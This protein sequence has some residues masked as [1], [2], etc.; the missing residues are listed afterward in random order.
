MTVSAQHELPFANYKRDPVRSVQQPVKEKVS[1]AKFPAAFAA[2]KFSNARGWMALRA[3][4]LRR[5]VSYWARPELRRCSSSCSVGRVA[6]HEPCAQFL[7]SLIDTSKKTQPQNAN[8]ALR[9]SSNRSVQTQV[10]CG[11]TIRSTG[12]L[13]AGGKRPVISFWAFCHLPQVPGYLKR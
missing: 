8:A 9:H 1:A 13:A 7:P 10:Q 6:L 5:A 3:G 2:P 4:V 11:L 12:A